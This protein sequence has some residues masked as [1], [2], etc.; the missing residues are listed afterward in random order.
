M[1]HAGKHFVVRARV[2]VGARSARPASLACTAR[3]GTIPVKTSVVTG[4]R[5]YTGCALTVHA[6]TAGKK[7][8]VVLKLGSSLVACN[9]SRRAWVRLSPHHKTTTLCSAS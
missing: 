3:V 7:L 9:Y 1:P 2:V 6:R 8:V 4:P 5:Q